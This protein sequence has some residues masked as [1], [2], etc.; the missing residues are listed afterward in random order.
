MQQACF[1]GCLHHQADHL[2]CHVYFS[3]ASGA[4]DRMKPYGAFGRERLGLG[5]AILSVRPAGAG[6]QRVS[7]GRGLRIA[8]FPRLDF[9]DRA[10]TVVTAL[11]SGFFLLD[12]FLLSRE[13]LAAA[14][15]LVFFLVV[16]RSEE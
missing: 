16:M 4:V 14:V 13:L 15:H 6:G 3:V 8:G 1:A 5:G 11:Y 12:F 7:G 10:V 2:V 9:S